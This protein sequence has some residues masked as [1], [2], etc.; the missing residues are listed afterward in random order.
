M[1]IPSVVIAAKSGELQVQ[2]EVGTEYPTPIAGWGRATH[3]RV[4]A[5]HFGVVSRM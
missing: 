4:S 2:E 3:Q 1:F 5:K